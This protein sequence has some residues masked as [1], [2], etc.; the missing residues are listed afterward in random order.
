MLQVKSRCNVSQHL[1]NSISDFSPRFGVDCTSVD[2]PDTFFH[3]IPVLTTMSDDARG[4]KADAFRKAK[5]FAKKYLDEHAQDYGNLFQGQ[6]QNF[7]PF[8]KLS[9]FFP[10]NL[11]NP[12]AQ[13]PSSSSS[14]SL[15]PLQS[16]QSQPYAANQPSDYSYQQPESHPAN[17]PYHVGNAALYGPKPPAALPQQTSVLPSP[18]IEQIHT[19]PYSA[20]VKFGSEAVREACKGLSRVIT[21]GD[22]NDLKLFGTQLRATDPNAI[23]QN[24]ETCLEDRIPCFAVSYVQL[25][26]QHAEGRF[27][28][29]SHGWHNLHTALAEVRKAGVHRC[30]L[31]LDQ[32]LWIRDASTGSWA[33]TGLMPYV[34]WPVISLS[35][36]VPGRDRT[37]PTY[38][39]MWPFVEEVAGLWSLGVLMTSEFRSAA[40]VRGDVRRWVSFNHRQKLEPE[41][42]FELLLK[43][44][45][46]GA[47]DPLE[48]G[49]KEDVEELKDMARWN[50][51]C[52]AKHPVV[53]PGWRDRIARENTLSWSDLLNGL[54]LPRDRTFSRFENVW[55]DGSRFCARGSWHGLQEWTSGNGH[56]SRVNSCRS[57]AR[58]SYNCVSDK[59]EF[60]IIYLNTYRGGGLSLLVAMDGRSSGMT[61]GKV[62]WTKIISGRSSCQF[63]SLQRGAPVN[64]QVLSLILAEQ[65]GVGRVHIYSCEKFDGQIEW[66]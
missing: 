41:D 9:N 52:S 17:T 34:L 26:K 2:A 29:S 38:S 49:W 51:G 3:P 15:H 1:C 8:P 28:F 19:R 57:V 44:I 42:S 24:Y 27:K 35:D 31:W 45:Y 33:H 22:S 47:A 11:P 37:A 4:I 48:T 12:P 61:R 10:V 62:A 60:Q 65:L 14:S 20:L 39:R 7:N 16:E 43:N 23:V 32:C 66:V 56:S 6:P 59:G 36:R 25:D 13:D 30:R 5:K 21:P 54:M 64:R 58:E 53:G 55:L 18:I 63:P 50:L 46:H 40:C